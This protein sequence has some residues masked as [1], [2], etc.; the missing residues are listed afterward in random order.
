MAC[1]CCHSTVG[2]PADLWARPPC[3]IWLASLELV[4]LPTLTSSDLSVW[5]VS[6][7][8][9]LIVSPMLFRSPNFSASPHITSVKP[10]PRPTPTFFAFYWW[11]RKLLQHI[12]SLRGNSQCCCCAWI[13][14]HCSQD[15]Q[16]PKHH[17][18]CSSCRLPRGCLYN[19]GTYISPFP[20]QDSLPVASNSLGL[21][22]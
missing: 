6:L 4:F 3:F 7:R 18:P 12:F 5:M 16:C 19:R 20:P 1:L 8:V 13:L 22:A 11:P 14:P 15:S 2:V 21:S 17:C 10:A 9:L